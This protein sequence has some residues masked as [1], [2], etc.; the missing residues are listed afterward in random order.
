[1]RPVISYEFIVGFVIMFTFM[2]TVLALAGVVR[3]AIRFHKAGMRRVGVS[4]S[5]EEMLSNPIEG[6]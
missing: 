2:L 4:R 3:W 1:M 6:E 5:W